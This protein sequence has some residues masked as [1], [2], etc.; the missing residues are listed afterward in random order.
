MPVTEERNETGL[1]MEMVHW[2]GHRSANRDGSRRSDEA[3][4]LRIT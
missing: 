1:P 4:S 3:R 2:P